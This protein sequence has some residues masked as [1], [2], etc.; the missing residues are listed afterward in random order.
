MPPPPPPPP[1]P[2]RPPP[3]L[4]ARA[5]LLEGV[6]NTAKGGVGLNQKRQR[7]AAYGPDKHLR[8]FSG[9][10]AALWACVSELSTG[11][12]AKHTLG[13]HELYLDHFHCIGGIAV[14][15]TERFVFIDDTPDV[16]FSIQWDAIEHVEQESEVT[17]LLHIAATSDDATQYDGA[18]HVRLRTPD[19]G[20]SAAHARLRMQVARELAA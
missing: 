6:K 10:D 12:G 17:L 1:P 18:T 13:V 14:M 5:Q 15:T 2:P 16:Q 3:T 20:P 4:S 19:S 9:E 7:R 11:S 8:D